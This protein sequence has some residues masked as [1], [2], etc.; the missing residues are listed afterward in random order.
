MLRFQLFWGWRF[1][2]KQASGE[3]GRGGPSLRGAGPLRLLTSSSLLL[4][5]HY[6]AFLSLPPPLLLPPFPFMLCSSSTLFFYAKTF[7]NPPLRSTFPLPPV[8]PLY[9]APAWRGMLIHGG[10]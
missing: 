6:A 4:L 3:E 8:L 7:F 9:N 10:S 1:C 5:L 2:R